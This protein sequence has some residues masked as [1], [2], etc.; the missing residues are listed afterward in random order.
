MQP[1]KRERGT[2]LSDFMK[3]KRAGQR[4]HGARKKWLR[5]LRDQSVKRG[6]GMMQSFGGGK[7][8]GGGA[9]KNAFVHKF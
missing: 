5:M 6:V 1:R 4:Q 7:G 2:C 3:E 8:G 9:F